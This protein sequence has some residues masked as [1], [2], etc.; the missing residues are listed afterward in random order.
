MAESLLSRHGAS[1]S[2]SDQAETVIPSP[3]TWTSAWNPSELRPP[4]QSHILRTLRR[5]ATTAS[6]PPVLGE[7]DRASLSI[8][9]APVRNRITP[10]HRKLKFAKNLPLFQ[11]LTRSE[12]EQK[13]CV[14]PEGVSNRIGE[15]QGN[16][17]FSD[18]I[19]TLHTLLTI[20]DVRA[21]ACGVILVKRP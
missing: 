16:P 14:S 20:I 5:A 13:S 21:R 9:T 1:R 15:T 11:I 3:M 12:S 18:I 8:V 19:P 10:S 17:P 4:K 7:G 6:A 2:P